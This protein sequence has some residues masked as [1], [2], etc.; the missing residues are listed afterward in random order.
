MQDTMTEIKFECISCRQRILVD[1]HAAGMNTDCPTCGS[2][3]TIPTSGGLN[4]RH[5][6]ATKRSREKH[7]VTSPMPRD[8]VAG[9][10]STAD[11]ELPEL[12]VLRQNL[13]EA[14]VE[15][16]RLERELSD[17]REQL[18]A[19]RTET[20]KLRQ[21][22]D[23]SAADAEKLDI[24]LHHAQAELKSFQAERLTLRTELTE[25]RE[26]LRTSEDRFE[27]TNI[28]LIE[29][30]ARLGEQE[31]AIG[32]VQ[33]AHETQR[34]EGEQLRI[35]RDAL[36]ENV[37]RLTGDLHTSQTAASALDAQ[38][39]AL[40]TEFE[41]AKELLNEAQMERTV[42]LREIQALTEGRAELLLQIE[43]AQ[44]RLAGLAKTEDR[45]QTAE[46]AL[47]QG[48]E[49]AT[50]LKH[51]L[52]SATAEISELRR[53]LSEGRAGSELVEAR[54]HLQA[55]SAE[56]EKLVVEASE[57]RS[58]V[59]EREAAVRLSEERVSSL[60]QQLEQA[61]RA[62]DANS[63][64]RLRRDNDVLRGIVARQ[65]GDLQQKHAQLSRL[66]RARLALK[67][68]YSVFALGLIAIGVCAVKFVPALRF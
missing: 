30:Q 7:R 41:A 43:E 22:A 8:T 46:H 38:L 21:Q 66:M 39:R 15:T 28:H 47:A 51:D 62:A 27:T 4:D 54:D 56:R 18:A 59:L 64:V 12:R 35:E 31:I 55:A 45:L 20:A 24:G 48:H 13:V 61:L 23:A 6:S 60:R 50:A 32:Q 16:T 53:M 17:A 29:A 65:N 5:Y 68:I 42:A 57:L 40:D 19:A 2:S 52:A 3:M 25:L 9:R 63:E 44:A 33:R 11:F 37:S 49:S 14:S 34:A 10:V 26:K 1:S 67:I 58:S 36:R